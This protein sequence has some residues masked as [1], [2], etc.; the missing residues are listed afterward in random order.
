MNHTD[1]NSPMN[2]DHEIDNLGVPLLTLILGVLAALLLLSILGAQSIASAC[3][4][5]GASAG[6]TWET[7]VAT[8]ATTTVQVNKTV[9]PS[10]L[11][12]GSAVSICFSVNGPGPRSDVVLAL[13]V[14]SS[15]VTQTRLAAAQMAASAFVSL[16]LETD[17]TAVVPYSDTASLAVPLTTTKDAITRTIY[18]LTTTSS[19]DRTNIGQAI[20]IAHEE[21]VTSTRSDSDA[22][23][24]IILL[25]DGIANCDET[26]FCLDEP[27][28]WRIAEQYVITQATLA[29]SDTVRIYTIGFGDTVSE[30]LMRQVANISGGKYYYA[31]DGDALENIYRTIASELRGLII[32]DIL[33]PGVETDCSQWPDGWCNVGSSGATTL[34]VPISDSVWVSDPGVFR[35][36]ATVNLDPGY[37]E[38]INLPDSGFCY[39]GPDGPVC[40]GFNNPPVTVGG[41]KIEGTVFY[42]LD[43]DGYRDVGETGVPSVTVHASPSLAGSAAV[44]S[45]TTDIGGGY[46]LRTSSDPTRSVTIAIPSG[47]VATPPISDEVPAQ[48]GTYSVTFG[49]RTVMVLPMVAR[50]YPSLPIPTIVN[51]GFE[52]EWNGWISDGELTQTITST[53]YYSGD[54][55]ALLGDPGYVCQNGVPVGSA[56]MEIEDGLLVP[57]TAHPRLSFQYKY[58]T[59]DT[60][61]YLEDKFDSFDVRIIVGDKNVEAFRFARTTG[62][63]GCAPQEREDFGWQRGEID[64]RD[65]CGQSVRIRFENRNRPDKWFNT[66]TFVDDVRFV[67]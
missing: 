43:G 5:A 23:K 40:G 48:T 53:V 15:M 37:E 50:D 67:P 12:T 54:F 36:T 51:G 17:Q 28:M 26:G 13:D 45:T 34:T 52:D 41:R 27:A 49:I 47:Y 42:D 39:R 46:V 16:V 20:Q 2:A 30:T 7:C 6:S 38:P 32:T 60:N 21:L 11:D 10:H 57:Y 62:R 65:Y 3:E 9:E 8:V 66:W 31:P 61:P 63:Y 59:Q 35:F 18:S 55:S 33:T 58:V 4:T 1:H 22:I 25:S 44:L 56:W 19:V 64:L 29:A 24:T 14:S